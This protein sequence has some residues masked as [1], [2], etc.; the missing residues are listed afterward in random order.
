MQSSGDS[1]LDTY[2]IGLSFSI[3]YV[4]YIDPLFF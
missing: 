1:H 4:F 3:M 2:D